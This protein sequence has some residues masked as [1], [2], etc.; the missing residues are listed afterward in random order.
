MSLS[1]VFGTK[2]ASVAPVDPLQAWSVFACLLLVRFMLDRHRLLETGC[3]ITSPPPPPHTHTQTHPHT[4]WWTRHSTGIFCRLPLPCVA[5]VSTVDTSGADAA[6]ANNFSLTL[7]PL[8]VFPVTHYAI[9]IDK[10]LT[11]LR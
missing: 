10:I 5:D 9:K 2:V 6:N 4:Q 1:H 3:V 11:C 7:S 8:F